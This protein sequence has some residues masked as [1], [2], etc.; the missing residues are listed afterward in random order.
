MSKKYNIAIVGAT[1]AVGQ[2][3]LKILMERKFPINNLHLL[4]S[5]KSKGK[6]ITINNCDLLIDNNNLSISSNLLFFLLIKS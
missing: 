1:G 5:K 3:M 2:M 4:A 6:T